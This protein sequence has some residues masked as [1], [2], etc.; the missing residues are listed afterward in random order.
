M[1]G[2]FVSASCAPGLQCR[3]AERRLSGKARSGP[4]LPGPRAPWPCRRRH[5]STSEQGSRRSGKSP[6]L[7]DG[8]R[9]ELFSLPP[10]APALARPR[11]RSSRP[12]LS[13]LL[14]REP[15]GPSQPGA[16]TLPRSG[17]LSPGR[18]SQAEGKRCQQDGSS[19]LPPPAF[20]QKDLSLR[21]EAPA[22]A[23]GMERINRRHHTHT[24]PTHTHH[25][26]A[27][28]CNLSLKAPHESSLDRDL[29]LREDFLL[30]CP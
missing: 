7:P 3:K 26:P 16:E 14:E 10:P 8:Q 12:V 27:D 1:P 19:D 25:T 18:V 11:Q 24:N 23:A 28:V 9:E 17:M 5:L 2:S 20:W 29:R 4:Q 21:W 22:A 30:R 6:L 13:F 15:G